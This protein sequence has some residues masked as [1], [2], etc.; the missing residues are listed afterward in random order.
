MLIHRPHILQKVAYSGN[1]V[2][3]KPKASARSILEGCKHM[4]SAG[5]LLAMAFESLDLSS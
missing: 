1:T 3:V 2:G 5:E 4:S